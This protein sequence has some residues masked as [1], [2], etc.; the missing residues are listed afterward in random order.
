[1]KGRLG[2]QPD[3]TESRLGETKSRLCEQ[4]DETESLIDQIVNDI[5]INPFSRSPRREKAK[6]KETEHCTLW[7]PT[8]RSR[9]LSSALQHATLRS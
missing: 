5:D 7:K 3:E 4:P 8:Q 2:E 9:K 1:M 6:R